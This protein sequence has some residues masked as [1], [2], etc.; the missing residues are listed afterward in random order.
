M[1]QISLNYVQLFSSYIIFNYLTH[2]LTGFLFLLQFT[3]IR[4]YIIYAE[5]EKFR[6]ISKNI[7]ERVYFGAYKNNNG[8]NT[9]TGYFVGWHCIGYFDTMDKYED[10][11]RIQMICTVDFY[12]KITAEKNIDAFSVIDKPAVYTQT[13]SKIRVFNRTGNYKRFYYTSI[14]LNIASIYPIGKQGEIIDAISEIYNKKMRA[15]VFIH[16]VTCAGKSSIG[17]LLAKKY[18]G[19]FCHSFN[20][21]DPGDHI[22]YLIS[23][24]NSDQDDNI[25][26]IIVLEEADT[27]IKSI[28]AGTVSR[29]NDVPTSFYNK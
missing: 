11:D 16:G 4:Y 19:K 21:T 22:D 2:I 13:A 24:L 27:I 9:G 14:Y 1:S 18:N 28:H 26:N 23:Q 29:N 15:T 5:K 12:K 10:S 8:R 17:Y 20:P 6:E 3:D 25:P 7:E